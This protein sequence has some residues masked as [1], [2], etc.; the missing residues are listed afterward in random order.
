MAG[1]GKET[2]QHDKE[3]DM[4][5]MDDDILSDGLSDFGDD[6]LPANHDKAEVRR[7]LENYLEE[8]RLR[9]E[10]NDDFDE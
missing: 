1:A 2:G 10:L 8:K 5:D 4:P 6:S 7:R 3:V 9:S